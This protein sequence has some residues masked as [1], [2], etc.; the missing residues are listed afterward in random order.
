MDDQLQPYSR[1]PDET[2]SLSPT[3]LERIKFLRSNLVLP[4]LRDLRLLGLNE[5]ET[6]YR[7]DLERTLLNLGQAL[8]LHEQGH[9]F[10]EIARHLG[11]ASGTVSSWIR[12][13]RLPTR[14]IIG[15]EAQRRA[16]SYV[17]RL[18]R[19][20]SEPFA[21]VLGIH[22]GT[23]TPNN[24][25]YHLRPQVAAPEI[26]TRLASAFE[27]VVES[28]AKIKERQTYW[29][30]TA[31]T[32][33]EVNC[34]SL[35]LSR[36]LNLVSQQNQRVPWEHLGTDQ[37]RIAFLQGV[38][39]VCSSV[40][41]RN[42]NFISLQ[43]TGGASLIIDI[44]HVLMTVGITPQVRLGEKPCLYI[45]EYQDLKLFEELISYTAPEQRT[46]LA[47]LTKTA[48]TRRTFRQ[49]DYQRAKQLYHAHPDWNNRQ[50]ARAA[51]IDERTL[52]T[53]KR[54]FADLSSDAVPREMIR[55]RALTTLLGDRIDDAR[56][57]LLLFREC[58]LSVYQVNTAVRSR[59]A[60][61]VLSAIS[62]FAS[63]RQDPR[64]LPDVFFKYLMSDKPSDSESSLVLTS[65]IDSSELR[66]TSGPIA[67][68]PAA[69]MLGTDDTTSILQR[70]YK[71]GAFKT[72]RYIEPL[73]NILERTAE[74]SFPN[75]TFEKFVATLKPSE[76]SL[77]RWLLIALSPD[78]VS[79]AYR[80]FLESENLMPEGPSESDLSGD[81]T[82]P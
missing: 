65:M 47:Q 54:S 5:K 6:I 74:L 36:H 12:G 79:Q 28:S 32:A 4:Y 2:S 69:S 62:D 82:E 38:F 58:G 56:T 76:Y 64:D 15:D 43:R 33:Y 75:F 27:S 68:E 9:S 52:R 49:Q 63:Q 20:Q 35:P 24:S 72:L 61:H 19:Q 7:A 16:N 3:A 17:F 39:D 21:Y 44:A 13:E 14:L 55:I 26:A 73:K 25:I 59:S 50:L 10:S 30:D 37:E 42:S 1:I 53:W 70:R 45:N 60:T 40:S 48:P 46:R 34:L 41:I 31:R 18:P 22:S 8:T 66:T 81:L 77:A 80:D 78:E 11:V 51:E 57:R 67:I 29:K 23:C 71:T